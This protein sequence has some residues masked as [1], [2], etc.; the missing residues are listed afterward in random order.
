MKENLL[1]WDGININ[2]LLYKTYFKVNVDHFNR[3]S[4]GFKK[5]RK[6]RSWALIKWIIAQVDLIVY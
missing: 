4:N 3:Q 5:D 2:N 6:I 1:K